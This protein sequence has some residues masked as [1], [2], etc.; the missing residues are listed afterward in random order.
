MNHFTVAFRNLIRRPVYTATVIGLLV[1]GICL[2]ATVFSLVE[3]VLLRPLPFANPDGVA[4]IQDARR[5]P[6][7]H[8]VTRA[9]YEELRGTL[10]TPAAVSAYRAGFRRQFAAE[11]TGLGERVAGM[12]V[13]PDIFATLGARAA[14]GRTL[15]ADDARA[16]PRPVVL[17]H[18][19]WVRHF[20]GR[21][22][23]VGEEVRIGGEPH[24]VVGVMPR[25]FWFPFEDTGFWVPLGAAAQG[26]GVRDLSLVARL[27][28]GNDAAALAAEVAVR[29]AELDRAAGTPRPRWW[30]VASFDE[31]RRPS[32]APFFYVL[33]GIMLCVL[34]LACVSVSGIL[35]VRTLSRR[36]EMVIRAAV[37][38]TRW[39]VAQSLLAETAL[40]VGA[41]AVVGALASAAA[42]RVLARSVGD[43]GL[44]DLMSGGSSMR[45]FGASVLA[46]LL[47][48]AV[49]SVGPVLEANRV[50]LSQAMK[51][52]A[53]GAGTTRR[54]HR[55]RRALVALQL[56]L[57][58]V[59]LTTSGLLLRDVRRQQDWDFGFDPRGVLRM[60]LRGSLAMEGLLPGVLQRVEAIPGVTW[61]GAS[62]RF[63]P[64][65]GTV[66]AETGGAEVPCRCERVTSGYLPA[67]GLTLVQG[68]ALIAGD[69]AGGGVVVDEVL[70]RRLWGSESPLGK[71]VK[72]GDAGA[73]A[74]W[75]TVV[76]VARVVEF[77]RVSSQERAAL[78]GA[79]YAA[80]QVGSAAS[81]A[82]LVRA[83]PGAGVAR[84]VRQA[85]L[86]AD[87]DQ[88]AH[89][90][91]AMQ[92]HLDAALAPMRWFASV[93]AL[94][95]LCA[96][97]IAV[98]GLQ[99]LV[100]SVVAQRTAEFGVRLALGARPGQVVR[101]VFRDVART[102]AVGVGVGLAA[103]YAAAQV[104]V[105]G[106]L[107]EASAAPSTAL[108]VALILVAAASVA[109]V[110]P[111][112]RA[113][114]L[115]PTDAFRRIG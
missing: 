2:N 103:A 14:L 27:R 89:S 95:A 35:L 91:S 54:G 11:M 52:G 15:G 39:H 48:M 87:P 61:A 88:P 110:P 51:D 47:A 32:D 23:A 24:R 50:D 67:L 83:A 105:H 20:E 62:E 49:C 25:G 37:G 101:L 85:V 41:S 19:V 55:L 109:C 12:S 94:L 3:S 81:A 59:L 108:Y 86:A 60:D 30:R 113:L 68:R 112:L 76:G 42:G 34:A 7:G 111:A 22:G 45:L 115:N 46:A 26:A 70:A 90:L 96:L 75:R 104:L 17:S 106:V 64:E 107:E 74:E 56:V 44:Q 29:G 4:T 28:S 5:A 57:S 36:R 16:D 97:V 63:V 77:T 102:V 31:V 78:P 99:G 79:L 53:Q 114:R 21:R 40:L 8:L 80:G 71:R 100:G 93:A 82:L 43:T 66:T 13:T 73:Q 1:I 69:A 65:G 38:A 33:Q 92:D 18:G 72:L 6:D 9:E 84:G 10:R 98:L 58:L